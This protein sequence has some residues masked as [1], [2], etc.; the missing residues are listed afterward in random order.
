M[1]KHQYI[2]CDIY[3]RGIGIF[4]GTLKEFQEWVA[5]E[6]TDETDRPFVNMV[7]NTDESGA[8]EASFYYNNLD[9]QGIILI[10]KMPTTPKER[11]N[12]AHE[13]LHATFHV[14]NFCHIEY[15]PRS[16]NEAF[17]YLNEWLTRCA[18]EKD[19]YKEV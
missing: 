15:D 18:Y 16:N 1:A 9:G 12:L 14:L 4:V 3:K 17:T 2:P 10:S 11:G 5:K 7:M 19:F 8:G 13:L 6:F